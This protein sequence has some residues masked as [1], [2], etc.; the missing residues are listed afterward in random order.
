MKK[1]NYIL[2]FGIS[3]IILGITFFFITKTKNTVEKN[4]IEYLKDSLEMEY[5]KKQLETYPF[6]HS[7][8][9]DTTVKTLDK[10]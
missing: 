1:L 5:N 3:M 10:W 8:I 4:K 2:F 7:E 6:D 9:K